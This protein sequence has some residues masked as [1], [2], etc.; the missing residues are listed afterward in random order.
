MKTY[1][2]LRFNL[3]LKDLSK[4]SDLKRKLCIEISLKYFIALGVRV[5]GIYSTW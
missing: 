1:V 5:L 2:L 4:K 3:V